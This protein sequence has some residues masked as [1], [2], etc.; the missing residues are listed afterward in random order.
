MRLLL[1]EDDPKIASFILKGMKA[2]GYAID[3]APD[4]EEGMYLAVNDPYDA[5]IIVIMIPKLDGLS[6]I[7]GTRRKKFIIP[8]IILS[9]TGSVDDIV[10]GLQ[11]DCDHYLHNPSLY[12]D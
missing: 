5:A 10:V 9:A 3:H 2:A 12:S 7:E 8:V 11:T 4:G 6:F 1:V